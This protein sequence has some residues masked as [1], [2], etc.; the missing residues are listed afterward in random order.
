MKR[1]TAPTIVEPVVLP[2]RETSLCFLPVKEVVKRTSL[3]RATVYRLVQAGAFPLPVSLTGARSAWVETEII[4][5][6][7]SR[8][9]SRNQFKA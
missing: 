6:M 8:L 3:S 5:W 7:Q 9:A 4:A 2:S 1:R